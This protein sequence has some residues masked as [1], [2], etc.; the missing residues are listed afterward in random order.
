[1]RRQHSAENE[2]LGNTCILIWLI[3]AALKRINRV[4]ILYIIP[5]VLL[6]VVSLGRGWR[7]NL[8]LCDNISVLYKL[9]YL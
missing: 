2:K 9:S 7:L 1:M 5:E 8:V 3:L 4:F 6:V